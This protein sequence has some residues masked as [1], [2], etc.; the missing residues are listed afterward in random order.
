MVGTAKNEIVGAPQDTI[1]S[2]FPQHPHYQ[3][4]F[5][6]GCVL[7]LEQAAAQVQE[8][9]VGVGSHG[10]QPQLPCMFVYKPTAVRVKNA[11]VRVC[12]DYGT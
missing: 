8:R 4:S 7:K 6:N 1:D 5:G 10:I 11:D 3:L 9:G 2:P 12:G